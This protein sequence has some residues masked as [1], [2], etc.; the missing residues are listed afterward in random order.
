MVTA[1]QPRIL[2]NRRSRGFGSHLASLLLFGSGIVILIVAGVASYVAVQRTTSTGTAI[3]DTLTI[4]AELEQT[5]SDATMA[6]LSQRQSALTRS[7]DLA[8][9]P[10]REASE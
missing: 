3:E 7:S 6:Q 1:P 9:R 2:K 4:V 8:Y 10:N 5:L